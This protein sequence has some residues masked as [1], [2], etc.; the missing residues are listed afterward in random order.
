MQNAD[1]DAAG[2]PRAESF[3]HDGDLQVALADGILRITFNRPE[4]KNSLTPEMLLD[5]NRLLVSAGTDKRIRVILFSG[6]GD[7]F[8]AGADVAELR[9]SA[10]TPL[11]ERLRYDPRFTP[12]HCNLYKP[13]ICAVNGV[14]AGAG[15]HFVADCDIVIASEHASFLDPHVN[16]GQVTALEPMSLA[17][18]MPLDRVLRMVILGRGERLDA[19]QAL[20][21][22]MVSEVLPHGRLM[23]RAE[24]LAALACRGSPAAIEASLRVIWQ[25][26]EQDIEKLR[27][28][29]M[30]AVMRHRD[31]P[32]AAEGPRAFLEKREP[33]WTDL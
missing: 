15:L 33:V 24:E 7:A 22:H 31:H 25:C 29:G 11:E 26:I 9:R 5:L 6:V 10:A 17:R 27:R 2:R 8:C 19:N 18:R 21:A 32:D 12:R 16:V 30:D 14:C 1:P 13:S 28:V 3:A 23:D 20:A 4:K